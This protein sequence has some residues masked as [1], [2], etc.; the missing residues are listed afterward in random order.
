MAKSGAWC[1]GLG[2]WIWPFG[3]V[4]L[5]LSVAAMLVSGG[6]GVGTGF[7]PTDFNPNLVSDSFA[8][9]ACGCTKIHGGRWQHLWQGYVQPGL[10]VSANLASR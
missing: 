10:I 2:V 4:L 6:T 5:N 1:T 3:C 9:V 8:S 7:K